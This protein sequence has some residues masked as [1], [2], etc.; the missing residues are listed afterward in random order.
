ME[1]SLYHG[2]IKLRFE[3]G[4][5]TNIRLR[6]II[7]NAH[8]LLGSQINISISGSNFS[9]KGEE[10]I[11]VAEHLEFVISKVANKYIVA[12]SKLDG[13]QRELSL[14]ENTEYTVYIRERPKKL[15]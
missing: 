10:D 14:I 15:L 4:G 11:F 1:R 5:L 8:D 9:Q 7:E 2:V 12:K 13:V 3:E 6:Q